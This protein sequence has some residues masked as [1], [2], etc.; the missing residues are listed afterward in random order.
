MLVEKIVKYYKKPH[1]VDPLGLPWDP[2][3]THGGV[4]LPWLPQN[5]SNLPVILKISSLPSGPLAPECPET[6]SPNIYKN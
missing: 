1:S 2:Q 4:V 3:G 5:T 6:P